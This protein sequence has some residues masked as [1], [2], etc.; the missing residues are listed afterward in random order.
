[1]SE[2]EIVEIEIQLLILKDKSDR[3]LARFE[4]AFSEDENA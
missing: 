2:L 4:L 3:V 1:M